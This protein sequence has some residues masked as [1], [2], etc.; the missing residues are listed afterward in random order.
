[1]YAQAGYI[2]IVLLRHWSD[3]SASYH[4]SLKVNKVIYVTVLPVTE[5]VAQAR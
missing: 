2:C 3:I 1:M 5:A 4:N